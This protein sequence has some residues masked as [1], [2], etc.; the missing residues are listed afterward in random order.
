MTVFQTSPRKY[1]MVIPYVPPLRPDIRTAIL[2]AKAEG[3]KVTASHVLPDGSTLY[4][5]SDLTIL[6]CDSTGKSL[7]RLD[8]SSWDAAKQGFLG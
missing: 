8:T 6:K 1:P 7:G 2:N 4:R 5:L 3:K